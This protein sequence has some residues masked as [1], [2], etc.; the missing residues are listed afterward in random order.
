MSKLVSQITLG[1]NQSDKGHIPE[2]GELFLLQPSA[3]GKNRITVSHSR[4]TLIEEPVIRQVDG[5][6]VAEN[7]IAVI[8]GHQ[9]RLT[10]IPA[11]STSSPGMPKEGRVIRIEFDDIEF[12]HGDELRHMGHTHGTDNSSGG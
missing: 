4:W 9:H 8:D 5:H 1:I 3:A 10:F 6:L 2:D 7:A 11:D 12:S